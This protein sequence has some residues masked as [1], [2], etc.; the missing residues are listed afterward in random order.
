MEHEGLSPVSKIEIIS[1]INK[2]N[3]FVG[4]KKRRANFVTANFFIV[5]QFVRHPF[6]ELF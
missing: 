6:V 2:W 4:Q 3:V 5:L 1:K